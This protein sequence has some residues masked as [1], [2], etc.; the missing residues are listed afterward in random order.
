MF[1]NLM[2]KLFSRMVEIRALSD[3]NDYLEIKN[4]EHSVLHMDLGASM[5]ATHLNFSSTPSLHSKL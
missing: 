3:S 2:D 1:I 4:F 5:L